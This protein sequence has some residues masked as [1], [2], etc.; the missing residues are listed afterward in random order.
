MLT[1]V[2]PSALPEDDRPAALAA[3]LDAA[4]AE[5]TGPIVRWYYTPMML[6]FSR[7]VAAA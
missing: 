5:T 7:Q 3:L 6:P 1:P 2:L 4:L